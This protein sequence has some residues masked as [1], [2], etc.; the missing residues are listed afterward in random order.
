MQ[1]LKKVFRYFSRIVLAGMIIGLILL[2]YTYFIE[3]DRLVVKE[4]SLNVPNWSRELNGFK[5]VAV[6]D[7]HGG[8]HAITEEKIRSIV[9]QINA[10]NPD[11]VVM[12]GDF[13]S[14]VHDD[15]SIK[16]RD[17]KMPIETIVQNLSGL[18]TKFGVF[19]VIGNHDW[20][21]D[22]KKCRMEFEK[23]GFTV[24]ENETKSF[25]V[26][27]TTVNILGIEDFWKR[28]IVNVNGVLD[29]LPIQEN[30]IG[31]THN[32]DSFE[33]TPD[34]LAILFAGHTHGGQVN[35]PFIGAPIVPSKKEFTAGHIEKNG[36]NL[37][38]TTGIGT[39]GLPFRFR[40]PPEIVVVTLN[41][42]E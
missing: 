31:I 40:V 36:K 42:K 23:V 27:N 13:V 17:L 6:S 33:Q 9:G 15:K 3:P 1:T 5:V 39:S 16:D 35:F 11:I 30:I 21:Y 29:K 28:E 8:S 22:E 26:N 34:S 41:S 2:G 18:K 24:L 7:I 20:W 12:L 14:Q 10:Q 37:Y 19:V 38:V 32:P 4:V 25:A